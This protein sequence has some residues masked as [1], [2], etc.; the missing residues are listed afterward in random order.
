MK[1]LHTSTLVLC[2]FFLA[3]CAGSQTT[4]SNQSATATSANETSADPDFGAKCIQRIKAGLE[5]PSAADIAL[6]GDDFTLQAKVTITNP[7]NGEKS[8]QEYVCNRDKD[9]AITAKL[10]AE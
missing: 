1:S 8:Y 5:E 2:A 3:S 7:E 6:D 10:I 9:R 4:S